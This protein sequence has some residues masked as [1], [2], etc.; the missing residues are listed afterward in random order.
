METTCNAAIVETDEWNWMTAS[1]NDGN[2]GSLMAVMIDSL[3]HS[4][5]L[6]IVINLSV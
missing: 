4:Y 1:I 6:Y 3:A 2:D 5:M